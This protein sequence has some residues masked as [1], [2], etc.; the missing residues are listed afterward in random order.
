MATTPSLQRAYSVIVGWHGSVRFVGKPQ[1]SV[2]RIEYTD[3]RPCAVDVVSRRAGVHGWRR[4]F[5]L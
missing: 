1:I 2:W 3:H 4:L 5:R